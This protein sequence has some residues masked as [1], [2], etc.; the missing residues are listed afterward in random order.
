[1]SAPC[2]LPSRSW[3][4]WCLSSI[5]RFSNVTATL[6]RYARICTDIRSFFSEWNVLSSHLF[7]WLVSFKFGTSLLFLSFPYLTPSEVLFPIPEQSLPPSTCF[8]DFST[9]KSWKIFPSSYPITVIKSLIFPHS[10]VLNCSQEALRS[11][12]RLFLCCIEAESN[13]SF[14][15]LQSASTDGTDTLNPR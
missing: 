7:L 10:I 3:W 13:I 9:S 5:F 14:L 11:K 15:L 4:Q 12:Q 8:L 2:L 6:H 1:M